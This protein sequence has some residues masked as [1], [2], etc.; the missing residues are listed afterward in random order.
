MRPIVVVGYVVVENALGV[1]F[2]LDDEPGRHEDEKVA[3]PG[4]VEMI[5]NE[6][7]PAL[8]ALT[9]EAGWAVLGDGAR[10]DLRVTQAPEAP[11]QCTEEPPIE[12]A[13]PRAFDLAPD[14]DE[15]LPKEKGGASVAGK[16]SGARAG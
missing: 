15:L 9:V 8:A 3:G 7:V 13:P 6:S 12:S 14:D 10:R 16:R 4:F 11:D 5:P 2:V 1:A